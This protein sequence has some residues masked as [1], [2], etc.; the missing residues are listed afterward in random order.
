MRMDAKDMEKL[1]QT[2]AKYYT[3]KY[4]G[5]E[6]RIKAVNQLSATAQF[7]W[8]VKNADCFCRDCVATMQKSY[9][10]YMDW[11]DKTCSHSEPQ[12]ISSF[13]QG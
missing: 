11:T 4:H 5:R 8:M 7:E 13:M 6:G 10:V 9:S 2:W 3:A 12:V 1:E